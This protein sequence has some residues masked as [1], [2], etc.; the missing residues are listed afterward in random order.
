MMAEQVALRGDLGLGVERLGGERRLFGDGLAIGR[1]AVVAVGGGENKALSAQ[2][3]GLLENAL[4]GLDVVAPGH[5]PADRLAGREA[6]DAGQV[7]DGIW[8]GPIFAQGRADGARLA[9]ICFDEVEI[10]MGQVGKQRL[11]AKQQLIYHGDTVAVA[12]QLTT[13][14]RANVACAASYQHMAV[15]VGDCG[16]LAHAVSSWGWSGPRLRLTLAPCTANSG[17]LPS[18]TTR[19]PCS[20]QVRRQI[21][22]I[23]PGW[24]GWLMLS[25]WTLS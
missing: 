4:G 17:V 10:G 23:S 20:R 2:G 15:V 16:H 18:E 12:Q 7:N 5:L 14:Q 8:F 25:M 3:L 19:M 21:S 1:E 6:D 13:Q 24:P 9:D 22:A 11:A